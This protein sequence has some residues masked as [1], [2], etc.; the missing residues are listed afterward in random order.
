MRALKG[1]IPRAFPNHRTPKGYEYGHYLRS[2]LKDLGPLPPRVAPTLKEAGLL[3]IERLPELH[4]EERV[5]KA[6]LDGLRGKRLERAQRRLQRIRR[7][8]RG[9]R[10]E[11]LSLERRL[12]ELASINGHGPA[13]NPSDLLKGLRS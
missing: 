1:G 11:L 12:E 6:T 13:H 10:S 7:D 4:A 9:A 5:L 2:I 8:L 3:V